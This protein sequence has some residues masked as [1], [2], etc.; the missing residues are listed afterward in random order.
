MANAKYLDMVGLQHLVEK[1]K[2]NFTTYK[3]VPKLP[4]T[5]INTSAIYLHKKTEYQAKYSKIYEKISKWVL[6]KE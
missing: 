2:A 5:D 1:I 4:S 6:K 3:V